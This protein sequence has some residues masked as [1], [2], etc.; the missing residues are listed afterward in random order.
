MRILVDA[1]EGQRNPTGIGLAVRRG[2]ESL[3]RIDKENEYIIVPK[4]FY[5]LSNKSQSSKLVN[6]IRHL[7]WKQIY[8]PFMAFWKRA[9][10]ILT[11]APEAS[12][13]TKRPVVI[14]VYDMIFVKLPPESTVLWGT[15]WRRL[16]PPS[17]KKASRVI[18]ISEWTKK[19]VVEITG[20]RPDKIKVCY[21]GVDSP[22]EGTV[23][24][25][26]EPIK[27]YFLFLGNLEPRRGVEELLTAF[28]LFLKKHPDFNLVIAGRPNQYGRL[29]MEKTKNH[30]IKF[31]G[32]IDAE[33]LPS[34]YKNSFAYVYPS[35]Y[36]GFGLTILEAMSY[37]CPVITTD[38]SSLP[39]VVGGAAIL[40]PPRDPIKLAEAMIMMVEKNT[41]RKKLINSGYKNIERFKWDNFANGVLDIIEEAMRHP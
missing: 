13:L 11:L 30:N 33:D 5:L 18:A 27:P 6:F 28:N 14:M 17:I 25:K 15:Y 1:R 12:F 10:L 41:Y 39:E 40:V 29:L 35:H 23:T 20:T 31:M 32:Y 38:V 37:G 22:R 24:E 36:E 26:F 19:D 4:K 3:I 16:V 21:L 34:L 8:V 9:D 7:F 2:I